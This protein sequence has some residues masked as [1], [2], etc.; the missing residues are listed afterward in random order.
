MSRRETVDHAAALLAAELT[1]GGSPTAAWLG[2]QLG[3]SG[4]RAWTIVRQLEREGKIVRAP[5]ELG[6]SRPIAMALGGG[7]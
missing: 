3:V 6:K 4:Q 1:A 5:A 7:Q 2:R